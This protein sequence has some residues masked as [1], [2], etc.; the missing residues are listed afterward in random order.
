ME[1]HPCACGASAVEQERHLESG[2]DGE[3]IA[4]YQGPCSRCGRPRRF[5]FTLD[6]ELPPPPPAYGGAA[7]SSIICP[8]QFA[9]RADS[10]AA[11]VPVDDGTGDPRVAVG[12]GRVLAE[13]A[14]AQIEVLKF[15]PADS[16]AVPAASFTSAE[17]RALYADEP[18]RFRRARLE[19]VLEAYREA[20][21]SV[22]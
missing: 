4:V 13:A 1:L 20:L 8:G 12:A 3:L 11:S 14:A 10:A 6:S 15:V 2:D 18:G 16:D 21:S 19:A 17:G 22:S 5:L 9:L 7:P